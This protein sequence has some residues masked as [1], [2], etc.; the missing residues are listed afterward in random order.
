MQ[1][2]LDWSANYW[3]LLLNECS[4]SPQRLSLTPVRSRSRSRSR[5]PLRGVSHTPPRK[6]ETP[7]GLFSP[8]YTKNGELED[9]TAINL[10]LS[11]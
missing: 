11:Y 8:Q 6:Q 9:N 4:R 5:T 2:F 1:V 7:L 10:Y 3:S